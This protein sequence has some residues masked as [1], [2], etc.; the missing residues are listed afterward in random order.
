[1]GSWGTGLFENDWAMDWAYELL[2]TGDAE[3]PASILRGF[4]GAESLDEK[5]CA[6]A[7]AAA[8]AIAA[9]VREPVVGLPDQVRVW[10]ERTGARADAAEVQL[11]QRVVGAILEQNAELRDQQDETGDSLEKWLTPIDD[12]RRRLSAAEPAPAGRAA[13][14]P[15]RRLRD[16][17]AGRGPSGSRSQDGGPGAD[18]QWRKMEG[19]VLFSLRDARGLAVT[20]HTGHGGQPRG[21][22]FPAGLWRHAP[23]YIWGDAAG[24][25]P[26]GG[27][28]RTCPVYDD[29]YHWDDVAETGR[30]VDLV[31]RWVAA[32]G[33]DDV[34]W[35]EL[36]REHDVLTR[37][38]E[39]FLAGK[40]AL[41]VAA[42]KERGR[43]EDAAKLAGWDLPK[44]EAWMVQHE[45]KLIT[46]DH[47]RGKALVRLWWQGLAESNRR[48]PSDP[49]PGQPPPAR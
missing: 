45:K 12:L 34:V 43:D 38:Y 5:E 16:L 35:A 36:D 20:L 42:L 28:H 14:S 39:A 6:E 46:A 31:N 8:E 26:R 18:C 40:R 41:M 1:M 24:T 44:A 3:F 10:V 29:S 15:S 22:P 32:G 47:E 9:S 48:F 21:L 17:V 33:D 4:D 13:P 2:E 25:W 19:G 7:L 27:G 11:A 37:K 23:L 49:A 30:S